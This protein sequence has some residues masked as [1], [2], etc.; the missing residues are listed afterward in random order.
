M[1]HW[2]LRLA[3]VRWPPQNWRKFFV[4]ASSLFPDLPVS[5]P[6]GGGSSSS[7]GATQSLYRKYRPQT[8]AG[9]DL[10]GQ[11]RDRSD[12][13][14]RDQARPCGTRVPFLRTTRHRQDDH[15]ADHGQ[16]RQLPRSRS[17][18]AA[19]QFQC[20]A[21]VAINSGATTDVIEIDAAS[22]RGIDDIRD[23]RD[24]VNYAP[25]HSQDQVLYHRR[26]ASNHRRSRQAFLKTLEEPPAHT[27]FIL[28]TTD[29]ESCSQR[30]SPVASDSISGVFPESPLSST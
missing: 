29:P 7:F 2:L 12:V 6:D 11:G 15:R 3:F 8:F 22:N 24:R 17:G 30:S 28:A 18:Q 4:S 23:L 21:C 13:A 27:K 19:V 10:V 25:T 20:A 26:G 16:G 5:G 14:Q 1:L 9:D